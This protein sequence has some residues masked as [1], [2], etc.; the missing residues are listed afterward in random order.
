VGDWQETSGKRK[1]FHGVVE[2]KSGVQWNGSIIRVFLEGMKAYGR[3]V[4][5]CVGAKRGILA[6]TKSTLVGVP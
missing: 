6:K 1:H 3:I 5:S 4:V 2:S